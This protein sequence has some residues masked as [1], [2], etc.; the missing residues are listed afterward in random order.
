MENPKESTEELLDLLS[1]FN[2]FGG[3]K[4]NVRTS[5]VFLYTTCIKF[6]N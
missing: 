6:E 3:Y 1:E 5:N 2:K 4:V